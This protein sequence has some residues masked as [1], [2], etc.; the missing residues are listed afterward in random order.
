MS[1][2][3]GKTARG[4]R[5][6]HGRGRIPA[7]VIQIVCENPRIAAAEWRLRRAIAPLLRAAP[8][9]RRSR[10]EWRTAPGGIPLR[11][12]FYSRPPPADLFLR[13]NARTALP[14][15][16]AGGEEWSPE[17]VRVCRGVAARSARFPGLRKDA[18]G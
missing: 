15:C 11:R 12:L 18:C 1:R 2:C 7:R 14:W 10:L 9:S 5:F 13:V 16:R 8:K 6:F 17:V 3:A 4:N